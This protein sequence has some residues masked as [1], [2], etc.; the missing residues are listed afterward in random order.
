VTALELHDV[1]FIRAG[2]HL[3]DEIDLTVG[4]G[5]HWALVGPNGAGK[6]T[7]LNIC[8]AVTFPSRGSVRILGSQMGRVDLRDLRRSIGYVNPRH[9]LGSDLTALQVVL[10]G[11]TGT[12]VIVPHWEPSPATLERAHMLLK[13]VGLDAPETL[14]WTTMSQGERGRTLIARALVPDPPLLLLDEPSTGLDLKAREQMIRTLVDLPMAIPG[15]TSMTVTHHFEELPPSTTH[16][17]LI[18]N[19]RLIASG[20]VADVLT[21]ELVSACFDHPVDVERRRG[22]W[23]AVAR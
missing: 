7:L 9:P 19:G 21:S 1:S 14:R 20:P 8:A 12:V 18:R 3:L 23:Y 6:T 4:R 5:E 13:Q 22:R 2:K 11:E 16:A 10:T 15:L 17:A